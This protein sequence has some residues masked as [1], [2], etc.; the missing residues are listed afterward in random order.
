MGTKADSETFAHQAAGN[1]IGEMCWP[2][3]LLGFGAILVY[4]GTLWL[5]VIGGISLWVGFIAVTASIYVAY[6]VLHESVHGSITGRNRSLHW[7]NQFLGYAM[8]QLLFIPMTAHKL[9]HLAHHRYTNHPEHD[10]DFIYSQAK[11]FGSGVLTVPKGILA[12]LQYFF[13]NYWV[14]GKSKDKLRFMLECALALSWRFA[15]VAEG[16]WL[17]ALVVF[18]FATFLGLWL[19]MYLFAYFVHHPHE[20]KGRYRDTTTHV[21]RGWIGRLLTWLWMYQNYHSIHHLY[22]RVPFYRYA[23]LFREIESVMLEHGARVRR[24]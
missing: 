15:F 14:H 11:G 7:L 5:L 10:P 21:F 4:T 17:E 2:T 16:Y 22:P 19:L 23:Q 12:Q 9:E 13:R 6:T 1:Y 8:G 24:Y 20:E 18:I 3:V